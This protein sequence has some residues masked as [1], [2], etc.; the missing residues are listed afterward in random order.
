MAY[1]AEDV[2]PVHGVRT[3]AMRISTNL[4]YA[5]DFHASATRAIEL[6]RAGV[7]TIWVA[8]A[9]GFD[10]ISMIGY[11][12]AKTERVE[13]GTGIINVFSRT[14]AL[15]AQT[16]AGLDQLTQGRFILGLGASGPQ[17]IEGWHGMAYERPM[18]RLRETIDIC[19]MAW[20]RERLVYNG[21]AFTLPLPADQG[22]G[23]GKP[24]KMIN[25]PYR[26]RIPIHIASL[27]PKSVEVCAASADGW[28][29]FLYVPERAD[30]VWGE[31]LAKGLA[32]RPADLAPLEITGGGLLAIGPMAEVVPLRERVRPMLALYIGGMGA[33]GKNF[34]NDVCR[35]YGWEAEAKIIQD[36]YLDGHKDEAAAAVP[37]EMVE[38]VTLCGDVGYV[39]DRIAAYAAH[40][41][42][43]LNVAPIGPDPVATMAALREIV[44]R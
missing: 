38:K 42:T 1:V 39:R 17:V 31:P 13:L 16:A 28:L 7:D 40:G 2:G 41:V 6:D 4:D 10:A 43:S 12:A 37:D 3:L 5:G 20:D 11:L 30:R 35:S 21:K 26:N 9:Y 15:I 22:T 14:P 29:P 24:I 36:L 23:L 44:S 19:R 25:T 18:T 32:R 33:R 8:E 27:G 34:Y